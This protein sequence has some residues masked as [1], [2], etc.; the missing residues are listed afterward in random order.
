[1]NKTNAILISM[2]CMLYP[3]GGELGQDFI[4]GHHTIATANMELG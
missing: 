1:M 2:D 4:E 3:Q